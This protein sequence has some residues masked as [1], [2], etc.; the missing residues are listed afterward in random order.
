MKNLDSRHHRSVLGH[1]AAQGHRPAY[2]K[3]GPRKVYYRR[4][5]VEAWIEANRYTRPDR[6]V[7]A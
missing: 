5:D 2:V 4:A 1:A 6:P 3:V 7:N